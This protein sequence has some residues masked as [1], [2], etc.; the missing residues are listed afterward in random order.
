MTQEVLFTW[1]ISFAKSLPVEETQALINI[2]G[3]GIKCVNSVLEIKHQDL[4]QIILANSLDQNCGQVVPESP[5]AEHVGN[6]HGGAVNSFAKDH[7]SS[8]LEFASND[9]SMLRR[10]SHQVSWTNATTQN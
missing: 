2:D 7:G 4:V 9:T 6:C 5:D 1:L 3:V 10:L 8:L